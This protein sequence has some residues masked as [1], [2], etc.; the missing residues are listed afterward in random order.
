MR[1]VVDQSRCIGAG[2]CLVASQ[3]FDQRESDGLVVVLQEYPPAELSEAVQDAAD[4]CPAGVITIQRR[5]YP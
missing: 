4:L 1:V 5:T 2:N 3:V